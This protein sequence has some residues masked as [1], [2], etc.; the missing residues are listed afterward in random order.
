VRKKNAILL[1]VAYGSEDIEKKTYN[2]FTTN[3]MAQI[4]LPYYI[5]SL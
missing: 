4:I 2:R 5:S 3:A 1:K